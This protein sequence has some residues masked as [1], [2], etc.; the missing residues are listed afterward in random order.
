MVMVV[1]QTPVVRQLA[2]LAPLRRVYEGYFNE[3]I[4]DDRFVT[5]ELIDRYTDLN[6]GRATVQLRRLAILDERAES[7]DRF[8]RARLGEIHSPA[9]V[10]GGKEDRGTTP[11]SVQ[12]FASAIPA[13]RLVLYDGVGHFAMIEAPERTAADIRVFL[14]SGVQ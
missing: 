4:V 7:E 6:R 9:L 11:A 8:L 5:Q 1:T 2:R 10:L 3:M 12:F 13:A 14:A